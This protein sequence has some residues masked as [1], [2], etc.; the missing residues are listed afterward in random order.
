MLVLFLY[1][2]YVGIEASARQHTLLDVFFL[3]VIL[4]FFIDN[5]ALNLYCLV[6][7]LS[8]FKAC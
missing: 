1:C 8:V 5:P 2:V 4:D 7:F 6:K 3:F